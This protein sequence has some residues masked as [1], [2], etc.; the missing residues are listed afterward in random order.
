MCVHIHTWIPFINPVC[1]ISSLSAQFHL[2]LSH[3]FVF[4]LFSLPPLLVQFLD[5]SSPVYFL[6]L[7]VLDP[8]NVYS[9]HLVQFSSKEFWLALALRSS[10]KISF[11]FRWFLNIS[12]NG[13]CCSFNVVQISLYFLLFIKMRLF[14]LFMVS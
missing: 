12:F 3:L 14:C 2:C 7:H 13:Y 10:G 1:S 8:P 11:Y 5:P 4:S 6:H 9:Y